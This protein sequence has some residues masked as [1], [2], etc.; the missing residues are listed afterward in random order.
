MEISAFLPFLTYPDAASD[1][2]APT[3]VSIARQVGASLHALA[4]VVDIPDVANTLSRLMLDLPKRIR[5]VERQSRMHGE[6]VHGAIAAEALR[7][8]CKATMETTAAQPALMSEVAVAR[9]RYHDLVII[10]VAR[11]DPTTRQLAEAIIFGSGRPVVLVPDG[12]EAAAFGHVAIAWDGS[13]AAARAV[14]DARPFLER[15]SLVSVVTVTGDKPGAEQDKG[16][17]LADG[18]RQRG[19]VVDACSVE[20]EDRPIAA[21]LQDHVLQVGADLLVMGGYGHSRIRDFVLG[22]ATQ[23]ILDDLRVPTLVSH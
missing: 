1:R 2:V 22:G 5:D 16:E 19:L 8:G 21:T 10:G 11:N 6:A 20:A 7:L 17:A 4:I 15:A 14:A 23:G 13:R 9:A 12:H 18:L 3:A